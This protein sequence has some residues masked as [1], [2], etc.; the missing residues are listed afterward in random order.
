MDKDEATAILNDEVRHPVMKQTQ[1]KNS[2][3]VEAYDVLYDFFDEAR[4]TFGD[5]DAKI[6]YVVKKLNEVRKNNGLEPIG[7]K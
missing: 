1:A 6:E 7:E 2:Y 3:Y 5:E 4:L